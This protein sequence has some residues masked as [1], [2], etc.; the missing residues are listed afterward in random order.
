MIKTII[1]L[2]SLFILF[3]H[4]LNAQ[5]RGSNAELENSNSKMYESKNREVM[6]QLEI[7]NYETYE[8]KNQVEG[9]GK[10]ID[11]K[12]HGLWHYYLIFDRNIMYRKGHWDHGK[13]T[14]VWDNYSLDPPM[15]YV[16]NFELVRSTENWKD[17]MLY[18]MKMGQDNL[19]II[20]I[21][22]LE[23]HI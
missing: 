11:G 16:N 1:T 3:S 20:S 5:S 18:R 10:M 12:P 14:G 15:G 6:I 2:L 17:G 8:S 21:M 9:E 23:S 13:K 19:L 7:S 22:D 4:Y